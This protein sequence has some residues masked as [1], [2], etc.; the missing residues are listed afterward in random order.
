MI[1]SAVWV[2]KILRRFSNRL[3]YCRK[4]SAA[5]KSYASCEWQKL[6]LLKITVVSSRK[7]YILNLYIIWDMMIDMIN[8]WV[9]DRAAAIF[10]TESDLSS[11]AEITTCD[12][13]AGKQIGMCS[14]RLRPR[15]ARAGEHTGWGSLV[16]TLERHLSAAAGLRS[17][18]AY[19]EISCADVK[20]RPYWNAVMRGCRPLKTEGVRWYIRKVS[21][22][23]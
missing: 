19:K 21:P 18:M 12:C 8:L 20:S 23:W 5:A 14:F 2:L 17:A 3:F 6:V 13:A 16:R 15:R 7:E 22:E 9:Q 11:C 4:L 10:F 1:L